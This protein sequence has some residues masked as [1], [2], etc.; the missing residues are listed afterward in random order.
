M[1]KNNYHTIIDFGK[2]KIRLAVFNKDSK[3]IFSISKEIQ[4][5]ENYDEHSKSL[6]YLIRSTEKKI[7]SHLNNVTVLFDHSQFYSIDIS[8]KKEFDQPTNLK[9]TYASLLQE[10]NLLIFN[11]YLKDKI[12]HIIKIN[13]IYDGIDFY[14]DTLID[15]KAKSIIIELKFLCLNWKIYENISNIFK[16]NNLEIINFYCSSYIKSYSYINF[17]SKKD[18]VTFL[19]IGSERSTI[20]FYNKNRPVFFNSIPIG[21]NHITKDISKILKLTFEESEK[22]KKT[23]NKS[24]IEFSF[25]QNMNN[26]KKKLIQQIIGKNISIDLLKKVVLA[27]VEE[28]IFLSLKEVDHLKYFNNSLNYSLILTGNGSNL[29]DKNSFHLDDKYNFE[30]ISFYEENDSEICNA[31]YN[32]DN[33]GNNLM[34]IINKNDK[35]TGFFENFFNFFSR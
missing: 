28:I 19:D 5:K 14:E 12:V 4:K 9:E 16:K 11:N 31:G 23:F 2:E 22:I 10:A 20:I 30:E 3:N 6:N 35:K 26:E 33:N 29:F 27:R 13:S 25:D 7:S 32:F 24:E 34:K 18:N 15:K 17:F 8:I 1:K 21:G